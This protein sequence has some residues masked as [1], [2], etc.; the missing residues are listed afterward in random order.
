M[1]NY[2]VSSYPNWQELSADMTSDL[3]EAVTLPLTVVHKAYGTC[4]ISNMVVCCSEAS[5]HVMATFEIGAI[6]KSLALDV[7]MANKLITLDSSVASEIESYID[8][9]KACQKSV[10]EITLDRNE[11]KAEER[12]KA[13]EERKQEEKYQKAKEKA[14]QD[15][16]V[17]TKKTNKISDTSGFYYALGWLAKHIG[18]ISAT[19]PD[20]LGPAFERYFG[21]EA[22]KTLVDSRAKSVGGY[23]KKWGWE[24]K[25][26]IKKLDE[27]TVPIAI[28]DVTADFSKGIYNTSF[29]WDI[30]DNYGFQFGKK[31]D[32]EK[33]KATIPVEYLPQFEKGYEI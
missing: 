26:S 15:F 32:F 9:F 6:S 1:K 11:V 14:L 21:S 4:T 8:L 24:F 12:L 5:L 2:D 20:Y 10:H 33:I 31:Q 27:T 28:K 17:M 18:S 3:L 29:I 19:L 7:L 22:P 25:C 30:V 23:A 13:A 16:E